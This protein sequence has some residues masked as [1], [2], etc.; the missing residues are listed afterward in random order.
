MESNQETAVANAKTA[1]KSAEFSVDTSG[2]KTQVDSLEQQI[3]NAQIRAPERGTVTAVNVS[4]GDTY[5]TGPAVTI[6]DTD[7]LQVNAEIVEADISR[8]KKKMK[9]LIKSEVTGDKELQG[10]VEKI[11]PTVTKSTVSYG[12]NLS[13]ASDGTT[14]NVKIRLKKQD[15]GLKMDMTAKLSFILSQKKQVLSVP[16]DAVYTTKSGQTVL[17][18][19]VTKDR[20]ETIR[21]VAV[22]EGIKSGYYI[23]VGGK[24]IYEGIKVEI[25]SKSGSS[26][27]QSSF[28]DMSATGGM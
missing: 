2:T 21:E 25:A 28:S 16:Y 12:S 6:A 15:S 8:I 13:K 22:T 10:I 23:E 9:V 1:I 7:D 3:K 11:A 26:S 20:K 24:D 18:E 14:Y 27:T 4:A 19:V 5:T 17:H